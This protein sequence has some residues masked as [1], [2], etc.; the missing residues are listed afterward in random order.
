MKSEK[1]LTVIKYKL[2]LLLFEF[3]YF[4]YSDK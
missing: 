4:S 2:F 1:V 3:D